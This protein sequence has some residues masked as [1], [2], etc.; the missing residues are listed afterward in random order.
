MCADADWPKLSLIVLAKWPQIGRVKT[1][2]APMLG[3]QGAT[4]LYTALL[5]RTL[6]VAATVPATTHIWA[7]TRP[8]TCADADA[9]APEIPEKFSLTEQTNGDVGDRM[10]HALSIALE[11]THAALL[12]GADCPG[13]DAGYLRDAW[14]ALAEGADVVLGPSTDGGY[15][16]VGVRGRCPDMFSG[17]PFSTP[18]VLALTKARLCS[19]RGLDGAGYR[20]SLLRA[21]EDLDT[22]DDVTRWTQTNPVEASALF[23]R[24]GLA[25]SVTE[26]ANAKN[27]ERPD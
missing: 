22:P 3:T 24:A 26:R 12:I 10:Q 14:Q 20:V 15:V 5:A 16:L 25:V 13:I 8:A 23:A 11:S 27:R 2:L 4:R 18:E 21:L 19:G 7:H 9:H 17:I 6:G 1:R